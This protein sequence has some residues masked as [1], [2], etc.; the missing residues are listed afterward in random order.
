[1][2]DSYKGQNGT[3]VKAHYDF[4]NENVNRSKNL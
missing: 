4:M 2:Q 1:M 3:N